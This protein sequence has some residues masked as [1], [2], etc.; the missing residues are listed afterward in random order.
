MDCVAGTVRSSIVK[1]VD[2][3]VDRRVGANILSLDNDI[4]FTGSFDWYGWQGGFLCGL[5]DQLPSGFKRRISFLLF[6]VRFYSNGQ[7]FSV[8]HRAYT[9]SD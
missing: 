5:D 8:R 4:I 6:L 9:A 2:L 7:S 3:R 1:S